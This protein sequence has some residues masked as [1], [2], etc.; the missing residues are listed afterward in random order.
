MTIF[1]RR[2]G[3]CMVLMLWAAIAPAQSVYKSVDAEGN[4]VYS[5]SP[6]PAAVQTET[7]AI[8][9]APT[10]QQVEQA[11]Q[12]TRQLQESGDALERARKQRESELAEKRR[13]AEERRQQLET[14]QRLARLEQRQNQQ[15]YREW[16]AYYS[17]PYPRPPIWHE[18]PDGPSYP[19]V[20]PLPGIPRASR[21]SGGAEHATQGARHAH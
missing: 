8:D 2:F 4:V 3:A 21:G 13:L 20:T 18:P 9:P 12:L 19:V 11:R 6:A 5:D 14:D 15:D 7:V 16:G 10:E 1:E 17:Y